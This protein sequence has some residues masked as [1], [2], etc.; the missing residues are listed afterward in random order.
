[1]FEDSIFGGLFDLD[2]DGKLD[3]FE[4]DLEF[5][6]ISGLMEEDEDSDLDFCSDDIDF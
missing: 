5:M 1:M 6:A 2:G 4:Q 3:A